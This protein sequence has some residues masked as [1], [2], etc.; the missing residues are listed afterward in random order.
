MKVAIIMGSD[1]GNVTAALKAAEQLASLNVT[2]FKRYSRADTK[3][4]RSL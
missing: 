4:L 2:T 1:S 3:C